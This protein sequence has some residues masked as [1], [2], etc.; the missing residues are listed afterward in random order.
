M[1]MQV[2][3]SQGRSAIGP[4]L[5]RNRALIA[6]VG[7]H[8]L[9]VYSVCMLLGRDFGSGTA[10]TLINLLKLQVPLFLIVLFFWRFGWMVVKIR[11]KRP[12]TWFLNDLKEIV[13]DRDRIFCGSIAFL[14]MCLFAGSFTV[15][16]DLIPVIHPFAWDET[17]AIWD[18]A[19]HFG[20]DPWQLIWPITGTPH[21]TTAINAAYHLWLMLAY[22]LIFV[23]CF[24]VSRHDKHR[25]YLLADVTCWIVGGNILATVFSS[26]G[27]VYYEA[28][29]Y[30]TDFQ[31]L[32][33]Q[34][35]AFNE[36]SPVWAL[37]LQE[38]L[39]DGYMN[40]GAV[41]GISAMPSM[42]VASTVMMTL[43]AY[44]VSRTWGYIMT[45]FASVILVGSVQLG[46]HYAIDGYVSIVLALG[47]YWLARRVVR[48]L[49]RGDAES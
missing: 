15:A 39:I 28:L 13:C 1:T 46:W 27:P 43:Y 36:I 21:I 32:M 30:G 48:I 34:L 17:F 41:K 22:F 10:S 31:P 11:P 16:K 5:W 25:T 44:S 14:A 8:F 35:Y 3:V 24:N 45:V 9:A 42:H 19:L 38:M 2:N 7:I 37:P 12:I 40:D 23:A 4:A 29:G 47:I 18:R 33:D 26:V 6:L 49:A 20:H